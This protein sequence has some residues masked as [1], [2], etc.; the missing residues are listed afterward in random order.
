MAKRNRA[1]IRLN[2]EELDKLNV[3]RGSIKEVTYTEDSLLW[4][5]EAVE[6]GG[7]RRRF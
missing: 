4:F 7:R 6:E 5:I 1:Y 3:V 2:Q